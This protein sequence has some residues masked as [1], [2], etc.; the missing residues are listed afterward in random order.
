MLIGVS[1]ADVSA[2]KKVLFLEASFWVQVTYLDFW[3]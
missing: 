2:L 3:G 1:S